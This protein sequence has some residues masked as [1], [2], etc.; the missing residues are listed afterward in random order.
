MRILL[1]SSFLGPWNSVRPEAEIF[2]G[3]AKQGHQVSVATEGQAP[4]GARFRKKGIPVF[5]CYPKRKV[6]LKTVFQLR[7]I[8]KKYQIELIYATNSRTIPNAVFACLNLPVKLISYRGTSKGLYRHDPSAYLTH[9]NPRVDGI[10]CNAEAVR[11]DVLQR[12]W[13]NK[14]QVKTIYKGQKP[15]WFLDKKAD[16][17][18]FGI[19]QNH[20]VVSCAANAR[21]S[22]GIHV[23][24]ESGR[25]LDDIDN[26]SILILGRGTDSSLYKNIKAESPMGHRIHLAGYTENAAQV[27]A[28]SDIYVQPSVKGEGL[29]K[30][31]QEA[32]AYGVPSIVTK[33]G[34]IQENIVHGKTGFVV[35]TDD[36]VAIAK[37]IRLLYQDRALR[38]T[39]GLAGLKRLKTDFSMEKSVENHIAFFDQVIN[40]QGTRP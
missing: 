24:L 35:K 39:M 25:Y 30:A 28:A 27:I 2:I 34:G 8:I 29:N 14:D 13:K 6:C 36:A 37:K 32:M 33:A 1:F 11:Q 4:Y 31:V 20:V 40:E 38:R 17:T 22:K 12:V 15:E 23:L 9:L 18:R 5:D 26:L 3:I 21:P 16:L 10:C 7:D 19:P